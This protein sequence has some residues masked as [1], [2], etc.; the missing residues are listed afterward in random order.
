MSPLPD[1][2]AIT[3]TREFRP[4]RRAPYAGQ[5][6]P[7]GCWWGISGEHTSELCERRLTGPRCDEVDGCVRPRGHL[8]EH[9]F[10]R[11]I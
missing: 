3:L 10:T 4:H 5:A 8:G 7:C 1:T 11:R 9:E 2:S 6:A